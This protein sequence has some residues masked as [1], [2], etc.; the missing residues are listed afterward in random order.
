MPGSAG[1][2]TERH[3]LSANSYLSLLSRTFTCRL[4]HVKATSH[5]CYYYRYSRM[6]GAEYLVTS[7]PRQ[8]SSIGRLSL[9]AHLMHAPAV[10]VSTENHPLRHNLMVMRLVLFKPPML[11]TASPRLAQEP[12]SSPQH[13]TTSYYITFLTISQYIKTRPRTSVRICITSD[14][15][16]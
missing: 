13:Q 15:L 2:E 11:H 16:S 1:V 4:S 7:P 3:R 9:H 12:N 5:I 10:K 14:S 8:C 6:C